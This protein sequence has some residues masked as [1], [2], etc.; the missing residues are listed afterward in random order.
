LNPILDYLLKVISVTFSQLFL[1]LGPGLI[2][3]V[4]VYYISELLRNQ[5]ASLFG[6]EF[7][8]YFTFLGTMIHELGHAF[9]AVL[10]GHKVT[11]LRL[12]DPD[13]VTGTLGYVQHSYNPRN[14]YHQI[15]NFF[16]G[17]GPV[18]LGSVAVYFFSELLL[19]GQLFASLEELNLATASLDSLQ[20]AWQ[21]LREVFINGLEVFR[22]L[23]F[24]A[25]LGNW[26]FYLF[27]YLALSIGTHLKLS[28]SDL[29][30]AVV[31]F[32]YLVGLVFAINLATLW[33]GDWA[34]RY[35]I[36]I[37]QSYSFFYGVMIF[38]IILC[39]LF[40]ALFAVFLLVG[41]LLGR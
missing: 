24:P 26:K 25:N 39:L 41:R 34:S 9:F 33:V 2:L 3:A 11:T 37:S 35:A 17:I 19:A 21:L 28:R 22:S 10:F 8:V 23:L 4:I 7:W 31:G 6:H 30:G 12:F 16:I 27:L 29:E 32:G 36:M 40:V 38:T 5:T 20:S 15:G 18:I 1:L 14:L 13:P